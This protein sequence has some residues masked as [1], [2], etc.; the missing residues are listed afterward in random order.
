MKRFLIS[1]VA[2]LCL[3]GVAVADPDAFYA[4]VGNNLS[5]NAGVV[6]TNTSGFISGYIEGIYVDFAGASTHTCTVTV[7]TV[8]GAGT[9]AART[10]WTGT[11]ITANSYS[12][13]RMVGCDVSNTASNNPVRFP[14]AADKVRCTVT[15]I[16]LVTN[17]N[18][19][20]VVFVNHNP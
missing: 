10:A 1:T 3:A 11:A 13:P 19:K 17:V 14:I 8:G 15:N 7:A 9:G 2:V 6:N 16:G 4:F 5:T 20:V 18:V 12:A